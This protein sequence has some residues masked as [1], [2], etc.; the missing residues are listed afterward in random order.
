MVFQFN[1]SKMID[2]YSDLGSDWLLFSSKSCKTA[3]L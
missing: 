3:T 1:V 2:T